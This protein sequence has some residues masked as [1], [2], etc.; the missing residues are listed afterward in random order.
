MTTATATNQGLTAGRMAADG[1]SATLLMR[2]CFLRI[3]GLGSVEACGSRGQRLQDVPGVRPRGRLLVVHV[4]GHR[5][6]D[7]QRV[8]VR[9]VVGQLDADG[10]PLD[11][12]HE[13]ARGV[14]RRQQGEGLAGPHGE[15]GDAAL[16]LLPPAVHV[17]LAAHPLADA[18]VGQ[19]GLLEV[20][21]DPDFGERA[22]GHQALPRLDVVAGVDVAAGHHAVD[23]AD[24]VAVAEVQLGLIQVALGLHELRLGL[25]DGGRFL[26]KR[27]KIRSMLPSGSRL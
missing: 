25:L 12:L 21:V 13:V 15:A 19:L 20:G 23:L 14:L 22:D 8:L 1:A 4:G 27:A 7:E 26:A 5:Q 11:D 10:Q 2:R 17:H 18:Q 9:V 16:E 3:S 6:S 24:D